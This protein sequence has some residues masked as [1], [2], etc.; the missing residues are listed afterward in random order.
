V[1]RAGWSVRA[2]MIKAFGALLI[3][4]ASVGVGGAS[5]SADD[6]PVVPTG[7]LRSIGT[8]DVVEFKRTGPG[9]FHGELVKAGTGMHCLPFDIDLD[10]TGAMFEGTIAIYAVHN[11]QCGSRAEDGQ[12]TLKFR[13]TNPR[14]A[15]VLISVDGLTFPLV[16]IRENPFLV[17][18]LPTGRAVARSANVT[19]AFSER[20]RGVDRTSFM[21]I[22]RRTGGTIPA[23]VSTVGSN[24]RYVLN[25]TRRLAAHTTYVVRLI[26]GRS[27]IRDRR[28]NPFLTRSWSFTTG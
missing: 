7:R 10:A 6:A 23:S 18:H 9:Q 1:G 12:I 8:N 2:P 27:H 17:E 16:W 28:N 5:T 11:G 20:V 19:V 3:I 22:D 4:G 26:G 15:D 14:V 25:P 13:A 21:L 24:R